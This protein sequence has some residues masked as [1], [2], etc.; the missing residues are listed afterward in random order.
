MSYRYKVHSAIYS[1]NASQSDIIAGYDVTEKVQSL[2]SEPKSNGVLH[3]DEG[4]IR[5]SK[6]ECSSK[7]F[8]IIVTVV[9]PS[10][11]IETR[12]TSCGEGSTLNIK[13]SGVVC[14]F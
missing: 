7:C 3:V 11:N 13:E 6:T 2:L 9:Y 1:C 14:S 8:A 10:G 12:F 5:N 4:K